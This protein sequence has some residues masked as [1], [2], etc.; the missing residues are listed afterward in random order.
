[1]AGH[2]ADLPGLV[3][4]QRAARDDDDGVAFLG[5]ALF[6]MRQQLG[7]AADE[8]AVHAVADQPF[9]FD[10]DGLLHLGADHATREGALASC[11][12]RHFF[13]PAFSRSTVFRRAM[14]LRALSNLSGLM[15]CPVA[16]CMRKENCSRRNLMSSSAS[17]VADLARNSLASIYRTCRFTNVVDTESFEPAR[18]NASRAVTSS[19]PSISKSTLPGCTFAIQYSML[20][21]PLPMRTSSGFFEIGT[22]GNTRI[23]IWPPRFT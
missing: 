21:L 22:S 5:L 13:S 14:L 19:T 3:T 20:P 12:Y 9:D 16:R 8:L 6:V 17:S 10:G 7:R 4:R 18:R 2:R 15:A 23:Q 1:M 11:F